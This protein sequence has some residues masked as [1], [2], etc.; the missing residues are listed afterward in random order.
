MKN[1]APS[2]PGVTSPLAAADETLVELCIVT[3]NVQQPLT[4]TE[5]LQLM[6]SLI[7]NRAI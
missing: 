4:P 6:N 5:G 1:L 2:H 7:H 3:G